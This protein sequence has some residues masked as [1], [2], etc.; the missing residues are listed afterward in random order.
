MT[1][2]FKII[3]DLRRRE[4]SHSFYTMVATI[5]KYFI[6]VLNGLK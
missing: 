4:T 2:I 6:N 1:G 5:R 3:F